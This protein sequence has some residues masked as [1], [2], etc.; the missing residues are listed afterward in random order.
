MAY[1]VDKSTRWFLAGLL[2]AP[3]IYVSSVSLERQRHE[4]QRSELEPRE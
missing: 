2:E 4:R 3:R 1:R